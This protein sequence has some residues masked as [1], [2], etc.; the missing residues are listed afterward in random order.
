MKSN[1]LKKHAK[2]FY[3]ASFFLSSNTFDK[4]SSLYNFCRTLDDIV[5]DDNNLETK[6]EIFS[7][8]K[9][10]FEN[11]N[12]NNQ[13]IKDI[14]SVI[15]NENIS[16][17]IIIDLFDGVET[18]LKEKV[19]IN[20]KKDLLVYSYRVAG[21]VGLMMSKILKV[22]NK[23]SL[24][25]AIDLGIAMQF[26]NIA[27]DVCEDKARN[28]QYIDHDFLAIQKII[29]ESQIF[30][31]NSFNSISNIPIRSRF[32]VI[33]ARR[34]YRKIGD[35]ILKQ[36]N[37]D[38]YNKAGKIYVPMVEKIIQTFLSV[39]DFI[40]LLFIKNLNYDNQTNHNILSQEIN[41]NERI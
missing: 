36:K 25:G 22:K 39:F 34:I 1:L 8:F 31:E 20:S 21:T 15:D 40:K 12:L 7:K 33:V 26:T 19:V 32:S 3:W 28:R 29:S 4:C 16:K 35:Y 10:D 6:K 14:W 23:E 38:N 41:L 17:Q 37:I 27:R 5:D 30:Y 24:K 2:S 13:I 11:K 9:R 18:D